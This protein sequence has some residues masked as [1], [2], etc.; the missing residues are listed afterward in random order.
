MDS[1]VSPKDEISFLLVCHHISI[2]LYKKT[3]VYGGLRPL[4]ARFLQ[5][6]AHTKL[7]NCTH[8]QEVLTSLNPT[9]TICNN[10]TLPVS[11][12]SDTLFI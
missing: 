2:G 9:H 1:Y 3:Q 5:Y 7:F 11:T 12:P 6:T 10:A 4:A 8:Y